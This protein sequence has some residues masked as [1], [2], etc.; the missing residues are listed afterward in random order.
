MAGVVS[1]DL[2]VCL[3]TNNM[4]TRSHNA[5]ELK[6]YYLERCPDKSSFLMLSLKSKFVKEL[7]IQ[8]MKYPTIVI[9]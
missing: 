8:D 6:K 9:G 2:A 1:I 5:D 3:N 4:S 7:T